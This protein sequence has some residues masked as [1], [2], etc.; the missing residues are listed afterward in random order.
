VNA[1]HFPP[2]ATPFVGRQ[3]ELMEIARLLA[4]PD[5]RLLSLVGPGG[6]GKT[7]LALEAAKAYGSAFLNGVYFIPLQPLSSHDLIVPTIAEAIALQFYTG[8]EAQQ[9]LLEYVHEKSLL[10]VL[11]NF[12]HLLE[13]AALVSNILNHAPALK[14]LVTSRERLNLVEEWA[15]EVR[16]LAVPQAETERDIEDYDAVQLFLQQARRVQVGFTLATA[17]KAAAVHICQLVGGMPL[18]IELAA[19]WV[20]ALSCQEIALEIERSL[21]ILSTS[22]RNVAPRHRNMHVVLDHSWA[23]LSADERDVYKKLSVFRGKFR[24]EAAQYVAGATLHTLSSLVDKS[25]LRVD[26]LGYYEIHELLRQYAQE[27][28][29]MLP[30]E[31]EHTCD[32][33]AGYYAEFMGRREAS[34]KGSLQEE[35]Y[36]EIE[37]EFDNV[38]AAWEWSITHHSTKDVER[39]LWSLKEFFDVRCRFYEGEAA[40]ATA[41][42]AFENGT[43]DREKDYILGQLYARQGWFSTRLGAYEKARQEFHKS[44]VILRRLKCGQEMAF[45]LAGLGGVSTYLGDY[46]DADSYLAEALALA[47]EFDL[48]AEIALALLGQLR[49]AAI[50]GR[51][52]QGRRLAENC[53]AASRQVP[54]TCIESAALNWLAII[55]YELGDH[56]EAKRLLQDSLVKSAPTPPTMTYALAYLG[57]AATTLEV[58]DEACSY[59][60]RVLQSTQEVGYVRLQLEVLRY[61]VPLLLNH[62][63]KSRAVE[64]LA[65]VAHHPASQQSIRESARELLDQLEADLARDV[66]TSCY[67]KGRTASITAVIATLYQHRLFARF[68]T[69][70]SVDSCMVSAP[71]LLTEREIEILHLMAEGMSNREI[72]EKLILTLGTVKWYSSQIFSKLY[73]HNRVQAVARGRELNILG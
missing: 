1:A 33:H 27:Q 21:D 39:Y 30:Q 34:L 50:G 14:V 48:R 40:F 61:V 64:L 41:I 68:Q 12:E 67:E 24:K 57:N 45:T 15:L 69:I 25:L 56:E 62:G 47:Q 53:I 29:D 2:D 71:T 3:D 26:A 18:G 73:A 19:A 38:R 31:R 59:F 72:A 44:L 9:Q 37:D 36:R 6:I 63:D 7:R 55:L 66:F 20:R 52:D 54:D 70:D 22:A 49:V 23:L 5:C 17:Q 13:G 16:G 46:I 4:N 8:V 58:E 42:Q 32:L 51:Y 35:V 10:L 11:D 65:Q 28:L 43:Q 60:Y